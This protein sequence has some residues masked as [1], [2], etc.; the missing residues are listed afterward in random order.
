MAC[1]QSLVCKLARI[2][3]FYNSIDLMKHARTFPQAPAG[4]SCYMYSSSF[5]RADYMIHITLENC[6]M[7]NRLQSIEKKKVK[8]AEM[9]NK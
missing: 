1:L 9:N 6:I 4:N 3:C 2:G 5:A 7:Q 8:H